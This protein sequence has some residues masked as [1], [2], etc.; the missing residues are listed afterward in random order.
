M[1]TSG[2][3]PE[4]VIVGVDGSDDAGL[5]LAWAAS[6]A[7]AT[8]AELHAVL[9]WHYPSAVGSAPVGVAPHEV[10]SEVERSRNEILDQAIEA[11]CAGKPSVQVQRRVIYGHPA[12]A[13]IEESKSAD[14]LVVGSRGH[15]G[16]TGLLLGSVSMHC[17]T[18]ASCPVT[19]V[20]RG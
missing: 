20:K 14:L 3:S 5:A 8:G 18:H 1:T 17:V 9:A 13:L 16:F 10:T 4:T 11:A 19:V 7:E 15:G 6:Y 2:T 12:Q